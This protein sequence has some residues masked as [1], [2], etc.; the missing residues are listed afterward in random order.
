MREILYFAGLKMDR[1]GLLRDSFEMIRSRLG[2]A[3][4]MDMMFHRLVDALLPHVALLC[5]CN[6][7]LAL[8]RGVAACCSMFLLHMGSIV[9]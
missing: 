7:L 1:E 3:P 9:F 2:S 8:R 5:V 4:A 6:C